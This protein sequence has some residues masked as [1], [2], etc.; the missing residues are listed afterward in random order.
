MVDK[1]EKCPHITLVAIVYK[2]VGTA[3]E[4]G[5]YLDVGVD[6]GHVG[7][8]HPTMVTSCDFGSRGSGRCFKFLYGLLKLLKVDIRVV[9]DQLQTRPSGLSIIGEI[10]KRLDAQVYLEYGIEHPLGHLQDGIGSRAR[11]SAY[12][13]RR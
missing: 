1:H 2:E 13:Y 10:H 7:H 8:P 5:A 12:R 9:K 6:E 4:L 11:I 3:D